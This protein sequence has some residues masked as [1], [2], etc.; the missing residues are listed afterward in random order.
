MWKGEGATGGRFDYLRIWL[1]EKRVVGDIDVDNR[2]EGEI[3]VVSFTGT[4]K[5]LVDEWTNPR[6]GKSP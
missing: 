3:N 6:R 4:S 1:S 5:V 2:V